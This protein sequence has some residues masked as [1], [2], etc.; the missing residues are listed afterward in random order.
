MDRQ[1][2]LLL[3]QLRS[4][5]AAKL[6]EPA[7]SISLDRPVLWYGFDSL[8]C[9]ELG[10]AFEQTCGLALPLEELLAGA[11]IR[12][13]VSILREPADAPNASG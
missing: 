11:S 1:V 6:N 10:V 3:S 7:A 13:V 8:A 5:V 9:V 12:D 2:E 4:L